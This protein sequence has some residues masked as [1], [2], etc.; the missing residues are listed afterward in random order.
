MLNASRCGGVTTTDVATWNGVGA[1][2]RPALQQEATL[3]TGTTVP[4]YFVS[5]LHKAWHKIGV[6][7]FSSV[8]CALKSPR[9]TSHLWHLCL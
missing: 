4:L 2:Q 3:F 7:S 9:G 1:L 6:A 5:V 8:Y